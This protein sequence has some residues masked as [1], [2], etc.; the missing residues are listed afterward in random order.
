MTN[1]HLSERLGISAV[2]LREIQKILAKH[3]T[4]PIK[5]Q[6]FGSRTKG[7][8]QTF[9]DLDLCLTEGNV[10]YTTL[11]SIKEEFSESDIPIFVEITQ[12]TDLSESF[13][14]SIEP[15]FINISF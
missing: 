1:Q 14:K 11:S 4:P 15:D 9:S 7:Q 12:E 2:H 3:L 5:V 8:G 13:K 6:A 10:G